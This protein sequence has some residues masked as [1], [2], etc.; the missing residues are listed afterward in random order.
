MQPQS[1]LFLQKDL[2]IMPP[3]LDLTK[4]LCSCL[5]ESIIYFKIY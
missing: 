2:Q 4:K 1:S 3:I 5:D